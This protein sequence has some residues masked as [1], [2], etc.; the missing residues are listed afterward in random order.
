[1][2]DRRTMLVVRDRR[3]FRWQ[4]WQWID[5]G[6]PSKSLI[7]FEES[8]DLCNN[9]SPYTA[10]LGAEALSHCCCC[11]YFIAT[12]LARPSHLAWLQAAPHWRW[13]LLYFG[14]LGFALLL[15]ASF[16][17]A[18]CVAP[19]CVASSLVD[20]RWDNGRTAALNRQQQQGRRRRRKDS[21]LKI[22]AHDRR[23]TF[24]IVAARIISYGSFTLHWS[25]L[26]FSSPSACLDWQSFFVAFW[27]AKKRLQAG[28]LACC[29]KKNAHKL[30]QNDASRAASIS[31]RGQRRTIPAKLKMVQL[32]GRVKTCSAS[33]HNFTEP[34]RVIKTFDEEFSAH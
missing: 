23:E 22:L 5:R 7:R 31:T 20:M 28:Q 27:N 14:V 24:S 34:D 3:P 26:L 8:F 19:R 4:R 16:L 2:S 9:D 30:A 6:P 11:Y 10:W 33:S 29:A 15:Y 13:R 25:T 17:T 21:P 1:M 12:G 18:R 32:C